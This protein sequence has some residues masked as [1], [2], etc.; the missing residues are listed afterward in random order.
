MAIGQASQF[1]P[2]YGKA[3]QSAA[4]IFHLWDSEPSIDSYSSGGESP[5]S[6]YTQYF[7]ALFDFVRPFT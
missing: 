1:A 2:D 6:S 3:K 4:R 5:V 7:C